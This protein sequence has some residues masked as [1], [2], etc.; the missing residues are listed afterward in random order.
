MSFSLVDLLHLLYQY[1]WT[2]NYL[3][4]GKTQNMMIPVYWFWS[5]NV[6]AEIIQSPLLRDG[7]NFTTKKYSKENL[8][9][10]RPM[11][12][13][14]ILPH[15]RSVNFRVIFFEISDHVLKLQFYNIENWILPHYESLTDFD[16]KNV[17]KWSFRCSKIWVLTR[18]H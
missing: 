12:K 8:F 13:I 2:V 6:L 7:T 15:I 17:V 14:L 4:F 1:I 5:K 11:H 10:W 3:F 16:P 9:M 18:D